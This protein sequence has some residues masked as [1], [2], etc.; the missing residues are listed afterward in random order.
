MELTDYDGINGIYFHLFGEP[1]VKGQKHYQIMKNV[2]EKLQWKFFSYINLYSFSHAYPNHLAY[3]I[4]KLDPKAVVAVHSKNPEALNPVNAKHYL[5]K[6]N[7]DYYLID[8]Q[9]IEKIED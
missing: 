2:I 1:L 6:E 5:P 8:G 3:Y 7:V 4:Q 9:L